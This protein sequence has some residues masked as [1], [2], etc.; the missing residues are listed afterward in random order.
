MPSPCSALYLIRWVDRCR[1]SITF[2]LAEIG[3]ACHVTHEYLL[4]ILQNLVGFSAAQV[5]ASAGIQRAN[6]HTRMIITGHRPYLHTRSRLLHYRSPFDTALEHVSLYPSP[7]RFCFPKLP[8]V[9][10]YF[11]R[12]WYTYVC[13]CIMYPKLS[14]PILSPHSITCHNAQALTMLRSSHTTPPN[15][16]SRQFPTS[17]TLPTFLPSPSYYFSWALRTIKGQ[18]IRHFLDSVYPKKREL[19]QPHFSAIVFFILTII[20][21]SL[22]QSRIHFRLF[23]MNYFSFK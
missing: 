2:K 16:L 7:C 14:N 9:F 15:H 13:D 6:L 17:F 21:H 3:N 12:H 22:P 18:D 5:K 10:S 23:N 4:C 8:H 11:I 1:P 20:T 19:C